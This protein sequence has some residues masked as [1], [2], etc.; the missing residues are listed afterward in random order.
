MFERERKPSLL[1]FS[2]GS[3]LT[4][5]YIGALSVLDISG[6]L[7]DVRTYAGVSGGAMIATC[8]AIGYTIA[9]LRTLIMRMDFSHIQDINEDSPLLFLSDY[10]FDS[11]ERARKFI[12][13]L[14]R[15]KG[16]SEKTRFMDLSGSANLVVWATEIETCTLR[17]FSLETTPEYTIAGA[18]YAS[19]CIPLLFTPCRAEDTGHLLVDGGVLNHYPIA[20]L[21][22]DERDAALG[23]YTRS[24]LQYQSPTDIVDYLKAFI[25]IIL[26]SK[27]DDTPDIFRAQTILIEASPC[28]PISFMMSEDEKNTLL[29]AGIAAARTYI[30][31]NT[32]D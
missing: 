10:G 32:G 5:S 13:A 27:N 30:G 11:G 22:P 20:Y 17:R 21:S 29:E 2:S 25:S 9:E 14:L 8:L 23:F 19:M 18:L 28:S 24:N 15:V 1:L 31:V 26:R 6:Y 3:V 12:G 4:I 16:Y 7:S